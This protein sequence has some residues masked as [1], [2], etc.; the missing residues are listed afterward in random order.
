MAEYEFI[1]KALFFPRE[2]IVAIGDL[3][4]GFEEAL[5]QSGI[6]VPER[7]TK[8]II[9]N[10]RAIFSEIEKKGYGIKKIVFLGD[11]KHAFYFEREELKGFNEIM[12]FLHERFD[13]MDI[14]LIKGN[15]DTMDYSLERKM[16]PWH[17]ES[18]I[19]FVHGHRPVSKSIISRAGV[20]VMGHTHP[21]VIFSEGAKKEVYK[22][23]LDGKFM[24]RTAIVMPSFMDITE[25]TPVN[26]YDEDYIEEFSAIPKKDIMNFKV[27]AIGEKGVLDFGKIRDLK[28]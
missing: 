27:H 26:F 16:K 15:H 10:L 12:D 20:I 5:R 11:I 17:M 3:H 8:D 28:D 23:F 18:G 24:G 14:I 25:G 9:E 13:D 2:G 4:L 7:Q 19:L 22:C 21:C 6:L 1:D